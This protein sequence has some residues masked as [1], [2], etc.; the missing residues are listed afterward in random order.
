[1]WF[2]SLL[3]LNNIFVNVLFFFLKYYDKYI[4]ISYSVYRQA[5]DNQDVNPSNALNGYPG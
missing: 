3:L 5:D 4:C 1:M 2:I